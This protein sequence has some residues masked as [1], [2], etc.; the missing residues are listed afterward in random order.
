MKLFAIGAL[1]AVAAA[2]PTPTPAQLKYQKGEI[3]A[4]VHFQM[5]TFISDNGN[6]GCDAT[7]WPLARTPSTFAP[8]NLN[9]TNWV[10]SMVLS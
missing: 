10:Q 9:T 8:S 7:T 2:I 6:E 1:L 4:L 3:M 5:S